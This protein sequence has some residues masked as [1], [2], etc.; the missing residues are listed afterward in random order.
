MTLSDCVAAYQQWQFRANCER[1]TDEEWAQIYANKL[2]KPVQHT[3]PDPYA[4]ALGRP[5]LNPTPAT[6]ANGVPD[7]Y[8]TALANR[9]RK[10]KREHR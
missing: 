1:H 2:R 10:A 6:D 4:I 8:T 5:T 9:A 7:G 3:P